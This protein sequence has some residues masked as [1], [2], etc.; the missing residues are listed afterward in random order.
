MFGNALRIFCFISF[1]D[2]KK[3]PKIFKSKLEKFD[4]IFKPKI[5]KTINRIKIIK[6]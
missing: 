5:L 1:F 2:L 4:A 3:G 6:N